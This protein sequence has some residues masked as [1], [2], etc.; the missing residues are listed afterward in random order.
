MLQ[1]D[2]PLLRLPCPPLPPPQGLRL[3]PAMIIV[4]MMQIA[5]TLFSILSGLLYFQEY[6]TFTTTGAIMFA[7]GV[8]VSRGRGASWGPC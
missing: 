3:F 8:L 7:M 1:T 5:W 6:T 4:P 2:V